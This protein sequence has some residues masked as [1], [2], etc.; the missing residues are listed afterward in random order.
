MAL[1]SEYVR[2]LKET[3]SNTNARWEADENH[4][5]DRPMEEWS[6]W[7]GFTPAPGE[8]SPI[9]KISRAA[10]NYHAHMA[11]AAAAPSAAPS[12]TDWRN[13]NGVNYIGTVKNQ[14]QCGSCVAFATAAL[15]ESNAQIAANV[16]VSKSELDLSEA[17]LFYCYANQE[18][19][20]CGPPNEGWWYQ[21]NNGSL[22]YAQ[23]KGIAND[24]FFAY[25]D[26]DQSCNVS[27]GWENSRTQISSW[28]AITDISSMKDWLANHGPLAADYQVFQDFYQYSSGVYH[29]VSG[30]LVGGHAVCCVGYDDSQQA[31]LFKNSWGPNWGLNGYFWIGYGQ[32]GIDDVMYAVDGFSINPVT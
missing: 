19:R 6:Q 18:G 8:A 25:T 17:Q 1:H 7:L 2:A 15:L 21:G 10:S 12:S 28:H 31:W 23:S 30:T 13:H 32:V 4:F 3:L 22:S 9:E 24:W 27:S 20:Q 11:A 29:Y 14:K 5:T 26:H 16:A